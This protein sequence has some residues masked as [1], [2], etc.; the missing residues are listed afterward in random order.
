METSRCS[1]LKRLLKVQCLVNS[2]PRVEDHER[3][4]FDLLPG[5][6][7]VLV[8]VFGVVLGARH[9]VAAVL[10]VAAAAAVHAAASSP[11][12]GG[13]SRGRTLV[14]ERG[15]GVLLG[16]DGASLAA[17]AGLAVVGVGQLGV[18]LLTR[19]VHSVALPPSCS[20][21]LVFSL[22]VQC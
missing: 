9:G 14:Q 3:P 20:P 4:V 11:G 1:P 16:G 7:L 13:S 21:A 5:A 19:A 2:L 18:A 8:L 10:A 22:P 6:L 12:D 15:E 17:A